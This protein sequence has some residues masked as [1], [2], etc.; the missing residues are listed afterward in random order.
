MFEPVAFAVHLENVDVMG[1]A[2]QQRACQPL[3]AKDFGPLIEGQVRG[4]DDGPAFV[5][6]GYDLKEQFRA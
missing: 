3:G 4:N 6:L 2:I 1:Q 5:A